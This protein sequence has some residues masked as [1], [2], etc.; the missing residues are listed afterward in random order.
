MALAAPLGAGGPKRSA[1]D[2]HSP[3]RCPIQLAMSPPASELSP[4]H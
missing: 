3:P 4:L 1:E 2:S